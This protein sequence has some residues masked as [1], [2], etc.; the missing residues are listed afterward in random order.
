MENVNMKE[1]FECYGEEEKME[2]AQ[3]FDN[4]MEDMINQAKSK[5]ATV[6]IRDLEKQIAEYLGVSARYLVKLVKE[7]SLYQK[8]ESPFLILNGK[9]IT[10]FNFSM[11]VNNALKKLRNNRKVMKR[12]KDEKED[13]SLKLNPI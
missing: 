6:F 1:V 9:A 5:G 10:K 2:F 11:T 3:D 4:L 8:E 12:L 7:Y 13:L